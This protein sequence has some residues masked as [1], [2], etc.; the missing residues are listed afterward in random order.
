[1]AHTC[2]AQGCN[3]AIPPRLLMCAKHWAT[4]PRELQRRV[5]ATYRPGQ[6]VTKDPSAEYLEAMGQAIRAVAIAEGLTTDQLTEWADEVRLGSA[7]G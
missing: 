3:V 5:W 4:V 2:H 1:M 6:E 7:G